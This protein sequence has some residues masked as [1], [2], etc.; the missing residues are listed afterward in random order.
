MRKKIYRMVH[1]YDGHAAS[2]IYKYFMIAVILLSLVPLTTVGYGDIYPVTILGRAVA[3]ISSFLGIAIVA[4]PAGI[5]TA[6]YLSALKEPKKDNE[7]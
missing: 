4:I 7:A 2:V 3:M 5:V 6:E 1:I